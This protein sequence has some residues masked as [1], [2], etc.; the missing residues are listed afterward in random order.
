[1]RRNGGSGNNNNSAT[2]G[3]RKR[4]FQSS[5]SKKKKQ[6]QQQQQ[7]KDENVSP[8]HGSVVVMV[9][10][11]QSL[12][13][14]ENSSNTSS[15]SP[16]VV[17]EEGEV[18]HPSVSMRRVLLSAHK[19]ELKEQNIIVNPYLADDLRERRYTDSFLRGNGT[20]KIGP[21]LDSEY[22]IGLLESFDPLDYAVVIQK[23]KRFTLPGRP[24]IYRRVKHWDMIGFL[25]GRTLWRMNHPDQN[26]VRLTTISHRSPLSSVSITIPRLMKE[27]GNPMHD[28]HHY[29]SE[30][31]HLEDVNE[32]LSDA[33]MKAMAAHCIAY[34][35][36]SG[37]FVTECVVVPVDVTN[38][39]NK[40]P[41]DEEHTL[42]CIT[43]AFGW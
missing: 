13:D 40:E 33:E 26:P 2:G 27:F 9:R 6:Q 23:D 42:Q 1:M 18:E 19:D 32:I 5:N 37:V 11:V 38:P 20:A 4:L 30:I 12:S 39:N 36:F 21:A 8:R 31:R 43:V 41:C 3:G 14:L 29:D 35:Y 25:I 15:P 34:M 28:R 10:G 22:S 7:S 16:G 24:H 17:E